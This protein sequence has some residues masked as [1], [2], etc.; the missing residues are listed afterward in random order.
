MLADDFDG[1]GGVVGGDFL[2]AFDD[3]EEV[4]GGVVLAHVIEAFGRAFMVVEGDAGAQAVDEGGAFVAERAFDEG[5][6]LGL[7]AGEAAADI[8]GA[9]LQGDGDE[10]DG[11]VVVGDALFRLGALVGGGGELALGEPV[12]AVVFNDIRHVDAAADGVGELAEADRGAVAVAGDAE[13]DQVAV[14]EVGAGEHGGHAAVDG[15]E[16][17]RIAEEVGRRFR[18]AADAGEFGDAVGRQ[19]EFEAGMDDGGRDTVMAAAGA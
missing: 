11:F 6:E 7:V 8:G 19:V 14:G 9:E 4:H 13:I 17:V 2:A 3:I 12:D 10:V 16:A 1:A 15:V 18:R 5:D